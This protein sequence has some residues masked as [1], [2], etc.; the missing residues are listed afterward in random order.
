MIEPSANPQ[1]R[2]RKRWGLVGKLA[3]A[4]L[5]FALVARAVPWSDRL[6]W[7]GEP[8]LELRGSIE[9]SWSGER[10]WF[11]VERAEL[12]RADLPAEVRAALGPKGEIELERGGSFDP[13]PGMPRVFGDMDPRGLVQAFGWMLVGILVTTTRWWRLLAA[14]GCRT[15]W[16]NALR[17]TFL[18]FFFNIVVPGLTGGD[19]VK[20]VLA[21]KE[22]PGRRA[23]AAVSVFVDRLIG[24]F[25]LVLL[26]AAALLWLGPEFA[27]LRLPVLLSL[28]GGAAGALLYAAPPLRRLVRF[29]SLV[30]RLPLG[31]AIKQVDE[32]ILVYSR[33]P[34]TVA[35]SL[36]LSFANHVAV[37][38]AIVALGR[39]FGETTLGIVRYA[40]AVSIANTAA[41][42]PVAP[43]GWGLREAAY[44]VLFEQ[45]GST[46]TL[47]LAISIG[48]GLCLFAVG[49][50]GGL[51]LLLPGA[52]AEL[53]NI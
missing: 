20:A 35:L 39:A 2:R 4:A 53:R 28:A 43:G 44:A 38:L 31:G 7:K 36:G 21:A 52:R 40:A 37:I 32:A 26:G 12:E 13:R 8:A 24:L 1:A 33:R 30:Q 15:G 10:V 34:W 19:L 47:G 3:F 23:Q 46:A 27:E 18:G 22:N 9:G 16:W 5:L 6:V 29:D 51:F 48:F 50:F 25:A 11:R 49:L 41:A 17:L 14:A 45:L 42:L